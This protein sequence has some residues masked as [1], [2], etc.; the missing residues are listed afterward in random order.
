MIDQPDKALLST[1]F[2]ILEDHDVHIPQQHVE[3]TT[4]VL[5]HYLKNYDSGNEYISEFL[6]LKPVKARHDKEYIIRD[7]NT[8]LT[9]KV[10]PENIKFLHG[11]V[12]DGQ[13]LSMDY[14]IVQDKTTD[15]CE[16]C[17][18]RNICAKEYNDT[19]LC[20]NCLSRQEDLNA[21]DLVEIDCLDCTYESCSWHPSSLNKTEKQYG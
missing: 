15:T 19:S 18:A 8:A 17:G 6:D 21:R 13:A 20:S 14:L 11:C 4:A 7:Q 9:R 16:C 12:V 10:K 3:M 1:I 5:M 2:S